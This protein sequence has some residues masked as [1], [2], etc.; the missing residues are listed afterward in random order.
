MARF[1]IFPVLKNKV[2]KTSGSAL[3]Q[4][5]QN[6]R[7]WF[8]GAVTDAFGKK[9]TRAAGTFSKKE[10]AA[11]QQAAATSSAKENKTRQSNAVKRNYS[12]TPD[13]QIA[14]AKNSSDPYQVAPRASAAVNKNLRKNTTMDATFKKNLRNTNVPLIG[15]MYFYIYD[16]KHKKTLPYYDVFPLVIPMEYYSDGFLGM[17]LHYVAPIGRA[18]LLD[19]LMSLQ[20]STV[21][22]GNQEKY[23]NV[24]YGMLKNT[25]N[26]KFFK[27]TIK[28]YLYSHVKSPFAEVLSDEWENAAFLP[29]EQFRKA[30]KRE[31]WADNRTKR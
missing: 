11:Q 8:K 2:T 30:T 4:A 9:R 27:P 5:G 6:S 22:A 7:D 14:G 29:V 10:L 13:Q 26:S 31:V 1:K 25:A 24:S 20:Q 21:V 16:P 15:H 17:N 3:K 19:Y 12:K 18:V 23:M 28:R